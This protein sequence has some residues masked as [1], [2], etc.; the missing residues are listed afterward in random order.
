MKEDPTHVYEE[1]NVGRS[2]VDTVDR[3]YQSLSMTT[4]DY[5][6]LYSIPGKAI[7][8]DVIPKIEA[9]GKFYAVVDR[10]KTEQHIYTSLFK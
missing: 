2:N 1:V 3:D 9:G 6:S 7:W 8:G 10:N 5:G 4:M